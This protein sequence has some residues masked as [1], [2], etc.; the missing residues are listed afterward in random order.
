LP[1][2]A[3]SVRGSLPARGRCRAAIDHTFCTP[4]YQGAHGLDRRH[5]CRFGRGL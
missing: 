1:R 3:D 2:P 4:Q 5:A